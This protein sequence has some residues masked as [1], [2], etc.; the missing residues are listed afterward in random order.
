VAAGGS[1]WRLIL[2]TV[3]FL[4]TQLQLGASLGRPGISPAGR[5]AEEIGMAETTDRHVGWK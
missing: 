4:E 3:R 5:V 2:P 1:G